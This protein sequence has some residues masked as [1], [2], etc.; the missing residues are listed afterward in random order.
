MINLLAEPGAIDWAK[1]GRYMN[2]TGNRG[3]QLIHRDIQ[4][5]LQGRPN[6]GLAQDSDEFKSMQDHED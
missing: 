6:H 5:L 4:Q 1:N 3:A 2:A